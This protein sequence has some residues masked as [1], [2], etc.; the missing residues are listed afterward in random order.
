M[1]RSVSCKYKRKVIV[2]QRCDVTKRPDDVKFCNVS[3]CST[4]RWQAEEWSAV[5]KKAVQLK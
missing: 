4:F 2:D 3:I 5:S 1:S